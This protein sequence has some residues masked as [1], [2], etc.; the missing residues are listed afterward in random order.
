MT[1]H[2]P[3]VVINNQNMALENQKDNYHIGKA[4]TYHS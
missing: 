1:M 2:K 4:Q 3:W